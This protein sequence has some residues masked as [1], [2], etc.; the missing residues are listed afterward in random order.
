MKKEIITGITLLGTLGIAQE[1]KEIAKDPIYSVVPRKSNVII[2]DKKVTIS[3]DKSM[4]SA[5]RVLSKIAEG[6]IL[7]DVKCSPSKTDPNYSYWRKVAATKNIKIY[8]KDTQKD[9]LQHINDLENKYGEANSKYENIVGADRLH[10]DLV[11]VKPKES[12]TKTE[13]KE[14]NKLVKKRVEQLV[15][16]SRTLKDKNAPKKVIYLNKAKDDNIDIDNILK[17]YAEKLSKNF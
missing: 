17:N 1:N 13:P 6:K 14:D 16:K 12:N 5:D 2:K 7:R 11:E 4:C 10:F 3:N 9:I 8:D 15:K